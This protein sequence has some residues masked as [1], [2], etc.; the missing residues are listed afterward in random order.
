MAPRVMSRS[1]GGVLALTEAGGRWQPSPASAAAPPDWG[2][3]RK[4]PFSVRIFLECRGLTGRPAHPSWHQG[5]WGAGVAVPPPPR[6][7]SSAGSTHP[8][9]PSPSEG[10]LLPFRSPAPSALATE[11][12]G[13][14]KAQGKPCSRLSPCRSPVP[15]LCWAL[16][17]RFLLRRVKRA[18]AKEAVIRARR[19]GTGER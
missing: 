16:G 3:C 14:N 11:I 5:S 18:F 13:S 9:H 17:S 10:F 7:A 2:S 12:I 19:A 15:P 4:I 6:L 1:G 8:P